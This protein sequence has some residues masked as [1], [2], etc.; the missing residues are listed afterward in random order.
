MTLKEKKQNKIR[1]KICRGKHI[2]QI[3]GLLLL[4]CLLLLTGCGTGNV[5][6]NNDMKNVEQR[7]YAT[8]LL[9]SEGEE[10]KQYHFD[11]GIA[12]ERR[13]GEDS[14]TEEVVS[15]DCNSFEELSE[16]YQT[17][18]G[19]DLSLAHLK[20]ILIEN[21]KT[22]IDSKDENGKL[23]YDMD[24]NEEIAKTCP[25]L[26]LPDKEKFLDYLKDAK[27][28]IG[29]YLSGLIEVARQQG[30]DIPWLKDYLKAVREG[31]GLLIYELEQVSEGWSL[32]CRDEIKRNIK[33]QNTTE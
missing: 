21:P 24:E 29:T 28:P 8:I 1:Y 18:K 27:E 10:G 23:L 33:I 5:K 14:Q 7:G 13:A 22:M 2:K 26:Q 17:V 16:S 25:V 11:L 19:K 32:K 31:T 30:K 20:V 12:K 15:F 6:S 9:I 3:S 4:F